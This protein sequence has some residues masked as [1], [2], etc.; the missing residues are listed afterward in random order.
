MSGPACDPSERLLPHSAESERAVLGAII[1]DNSLMQQAADL[2]RPEDF[3]IRAHYFIFRA[4]LSMSE[5]AVPLEPILLGE[6]LKRA[7]TFEQAGGLAFLSELT[8]GLPRMADLTRYA[9]VVRQMSARRALRKAADKIDSEA[10]EGGEA[11]E[12]TLDRAERAITAIRDGYTSMV[13]KSRFSLTTSFDQFM[14][15]DFA[16]G[17]VIAWEACRGEIA[18]IQSKTNR[19]KSTLMRN[20][21]LQ[22]A[23]GGAFPPLVERG[24]PRRVMLLNLEGSGGRFQSDLRVM[25]RDFTPEEIDLLRANF[26]PVHRPLLPDGQLS[27]SRHMRVLERDARKLRVDVIIIDTASKAFAIRNEND[28][29]EIANYVMK[30][31]DDLA[32]RLNCLVALS[33]HIGKDRSEEGATREQAHRGRGASA[34]ADFSASIFNLEADQR[35]KNRATLICGKR[36]NG[37]DY[38][39]VLRL[40]RETRWFEATDETPAKPVTN[41]DLVLEAMRAAGR[42]QVATGEVVGALAG[43]MSRNTAMNCLNRLADLGR[44]AKVRQGWWSLVGV[45]PTCTASLEAWATCANCGAGEQTFV[46]FGGGEKSSLSPNGNGA[47][48]GAHV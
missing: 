28:N 17:E 48:G 15:T 44:V 41:D 31:L 18:L 14:S 5:R 34:W 9:D 25:T 3:Y 46:G 36:K 43:K 24:E 11:I 23:T 10:S 22:L 29:A 7:G 30:P 35:D 21:A 33:H 39:R 2:L 1:L 45:C 8:H 37:E 12:D 42:A 13:G 20:A 32:C 16:D 40:N 47:K 19:G 26:F 4:M 38:E 6:E 27:L